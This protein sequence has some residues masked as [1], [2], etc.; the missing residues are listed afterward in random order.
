MHVD[1]WNE[2]EDFIMKKMEEEN[3]V[4]V[5]VGISLEGKTIYQKGFGLRDIDR[6]LPVT[7]E[8]NFGIASVTKSFTALAIMMLEAQGLLSI[9]DPV[10]KHL[11]ELKING[12]KDMSAIKIHHLLSHTTGLPPMERKEHINNYQ[13]HINYIRETEYSLLGKPGE[14]FSYCNDSFLLLGAIIERK[15]GKLYRRYMTNQFLDQLGMNRST[16]SLEEL[17]KMDNVSVPYHYNKTSNQLEQVAW[18]TLGTF[19]TGGGIRSNVVDLLKYGQLFVGDQYHFIE[20]MWKPFI[21]VGRD[22]FYGYALNNT[23]NYADQW[24]VVQHGGGQPGVSSNF[25]FIPE[26]KLVI[27]VLTNVGGVSVGEL[28]SAALHTVLGLPL[29]YKNSIEPLCELPTNRLIHFQGLYTSKEGGNLSI[30]LEDGKLYALVEEEKLE[31]RASD[32]KTLVIVKTEKP[33]RFYFDNSEKPWALFN[34]SRMLTR[35]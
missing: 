28:W 17:N 16:F 1:R 3:I 19:E 24:M 13:D 34:G 15:T 5:S 20:K 30:I 10:V 12:I 22:S 21:R 4:G 8:T 25:G 9:D 33:I 18:P 35:E 11:P 2:L 23:P 14:Y 32:D 29:D 27:T 7:P 31:L 26:K 6:G